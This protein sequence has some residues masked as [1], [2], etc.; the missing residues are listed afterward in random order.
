VT[1][2]HR[3]GLIGGGGGKEK[4]RSWRQRS[5]DFLKTQQKALGCVGPFLSNP[6]G[7]KGLITQLI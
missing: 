7:V 6:E 4:L 5:P 2:N 1:S 3:H